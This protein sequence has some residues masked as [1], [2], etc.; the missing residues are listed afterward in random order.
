M[1]WNPQCRIIVFPKQVPCIWLYTAYGC[2]NGQRR[3]QLVVNTQA[4]CGYGLKKMAVGHD[5]ETELICFLATYMQ[6]RGRL[7]K[8]HC[9]AFL[10]RCGVSIE[11]GMLL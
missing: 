10:P 3:G 9:L 5:T 8:P 6:Y 4:G 7:E 2:V 1:I 11:P